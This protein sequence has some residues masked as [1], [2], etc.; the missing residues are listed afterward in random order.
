MGTQW[1]GRNRAC[2]NT[3]SSGPFPRVV[4]G[5]K[6]GLSPPPL[7]IHLG[8][9]SPRGE[10]QKYNWRLFALPAVSCVVSVNPL[11]LFSPLPIS[12]IFYFHLLNSSIYSFLKFSLSSTTLL[13]SFLFSFSTNLKGNRDLGRREKNG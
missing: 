7:H 12:F 13:S 5:N 9:C 8:V 11:S 1:K 6:T 3:S 4:S 10:T 2:N